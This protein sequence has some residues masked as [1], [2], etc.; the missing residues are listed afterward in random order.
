MKRNQII[1]ALATLA[2]ISLFIGLGYTLDWDWTGF[3][4]Y[5]D[6]TGVYHPTK[7]L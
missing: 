3:L 6:S 5:I 7:T 2:A 1:A 4:A